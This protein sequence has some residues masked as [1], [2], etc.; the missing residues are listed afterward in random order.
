VVRE[1]VAAAESAL[2]LN[3]P[4][5]A[6]HHS[7]LDFAERYSERGRCPAHDQLDALRG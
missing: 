7:V 4:G 2:S 5:S 1:C 3:D 6:V